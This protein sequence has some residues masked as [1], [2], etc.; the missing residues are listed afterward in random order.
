MIPALLLRFWPWIAGAAAVVGLMVG[1][2]QAGVHA[3]R[4]RGEL[5][6]LRVQLETLRRDKEIAERAQVRNAEAAAELAAANKDNEEQ[7]DALRDII[8]NR[9][10]RG[11]NQS[12]LD[13]LL[14]IR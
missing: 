6:T 4:N 9:A 3:E 14:N 1:I 8:S 5:V 12:E 2:Y 10:D 7:I 11:L 13:G